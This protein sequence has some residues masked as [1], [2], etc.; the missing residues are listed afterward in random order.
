MQLAF[1]RNW[2]DRSRV[3]PAP[4]AP[5]PVTPARFGPASDVDI[6]PDDPLVAYF[7]SAPGVADVSKLTFASP[8]LNG[9]RAADITLVVPLISQ[10]ELVGLLNLGP[11][12]SEQEY[13]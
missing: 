11:R 10:G 12:L 3:R 7:L 1:L 9:L 5:A 13:S 2:W 8:A 6:A 4:A